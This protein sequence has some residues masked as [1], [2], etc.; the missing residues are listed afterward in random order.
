M[1]LVS[2]VCWWDSVSLISERIRDV[3][4][5]YFFFVLQKKDEQYKSSPKKQSQSV[6]DLLGLG[7][8]LTFDM[9]TVPLSPL[10]I[11]AVTQFLFCIYTPPKDYFSVCQIERYGVAKEIPT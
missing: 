5:V 2:C 8:L 10:S 1:K 3:F 9:N 7:N 4:F 6:N 11:G